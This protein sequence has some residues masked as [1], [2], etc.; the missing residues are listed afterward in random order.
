M[1]LTKIP[2]ELFSVGDLD[3]SDVGTISLDAIQ[4]DADSNTSITFS[5]SDV[6]TISAGGD[7]QVTFTNGGIIPSTDNDIDLGSSSVEFKDAFFDGTVTTDAI[8]VAGT[9][10]HDDDTDLLTLADGIV[11]VAGEIS[12]TTL[13]IGGTNVTATATELNHV[14][15]VTSAIQTQLNAKAG[16]GFAVAMAI[17]L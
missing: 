4:G 7:N 16:K 12:V 1:A 3:I 6:I 8:V 14:D 15:G 5:G 9:I 10:G 13:D 2:G 17:A 11:T